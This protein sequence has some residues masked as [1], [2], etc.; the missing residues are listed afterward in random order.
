MKL[1]T[2]YMTHEEKTETSPQELRHIYKMHIKPSQRRQLESIFATL[3]YNFVLVCA[4]VCFVCLCWT[5]RNNLINQ[6]TTASKEES[7]KINNHHLD[8]VNIF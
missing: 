1:Q 8:T 6:Y 5:A 3:E 2:V 7:S 4:T